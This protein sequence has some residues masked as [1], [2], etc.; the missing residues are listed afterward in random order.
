MKNQ[1]VLTNQSK[2]GNPDLQIRI[3]LDFF[4]RLMGYM[5]RRTIGEAEGILLSY[6]RESRLDSSIHML[7][8][9][10]NLAVIWLNGD[11][12]VVDKIL[13]RR[14]RLFYAS[15]KPAAHVLEIH[16]NHLD[17]ISIGDQLVVKHA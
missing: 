16:P 2:P 11:F 12:K 4:S 5:F 1:F 15:S 6:P 3:C 13:A 17:T 10:F 8:M 9:N 14:W 7:F